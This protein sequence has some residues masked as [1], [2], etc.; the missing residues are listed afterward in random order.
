[1]HEASVV[2]SMLTVYSLAAMSPKSLP[3]K[4]QERVTNALHT[5]HGILDDIEY[6]DQCKTKVGTAQRGKKKSKSAGTGNMSYERY[7]SAASG[8]KINGSGSI[9]KW[10]C[11]PDIMEK[12]LQRKQDEQVCHMTVHNIP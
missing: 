5:V 9:L 12:F 11:T 2:Q 10:R 7:K 1:M 8:A 4:S 6:Y 3:P